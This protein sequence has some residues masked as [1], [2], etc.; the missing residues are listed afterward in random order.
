MNAEQISHL[1]SIAAA[2]GAAKRS[3]DKKRAD[4]LR[5]AYRETRAL[6]A[7]AARINVQPR[8]WGRLAAAAAAALVTLGAW[9]AAP[10]IMALA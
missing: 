6:Y 10:I 8:G 9:S 3:G 7:S 4:E 1:S 5:R 2:I